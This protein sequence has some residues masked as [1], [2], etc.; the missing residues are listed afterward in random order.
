MN[1]NR[2]KLYKVI[3]NDRMYGKRRTVGAKLLQ[4]EAVWIQAMRYHGNVDPWLQF[5][6]EAEITLRW[7]EDV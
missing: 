3:E 4:S 6:I 7:G 2:E 5:A 1:R